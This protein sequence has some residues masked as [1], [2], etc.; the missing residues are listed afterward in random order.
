MI[1]DMLTEVCKKVYLKNLEKDLRTLISPAYELSLDFV[2]RSLNRSRAVCRMLL[3]ELCSVKGKRY[4]LCQEDI[5]HIV[6]RAFLEVHM[7]Y[8]LEA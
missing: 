5:D 1:E 4:S 3:K 7:T 8:Q 6:D 2:T